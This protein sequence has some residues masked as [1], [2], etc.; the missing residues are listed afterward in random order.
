MTYTQA[1][2]TAL[3]TIEE[4]PRSAAR[5]VLAMGLVELPQPGLVATALGKDRTD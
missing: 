2:L 5:P 3:L 4:F 1:E